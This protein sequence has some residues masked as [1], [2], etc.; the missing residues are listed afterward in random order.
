MF[1]LLFLSV[2]STGEYKWWFLWTGQWLTEAM[3]PPLDTGG[4]L[5]FRRLLK[6]F[7]CPP[8]CLRRLAVDVPRPG[9]AALV[10]VCLWSPREAIGE[11]AG[12]GGQ[13]GE[14]HRQDSF[15]FKFSVFS[16][17]S[18]LH[19]VCLEDGSFGH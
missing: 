7:C 16:F 18:P 1:W 3:L 8:A 6:I 4:S 9:P 11:E 13:G 12:A 5:P 17:W 2:D 15:G 19:L 14:R 10:H